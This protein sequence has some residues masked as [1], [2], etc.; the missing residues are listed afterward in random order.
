M[1]ISQAASSGGGG[2]GVADFAIAASSASGSVSAGLPATTTLTLT[3]SN[4][5]NQAVA[6]SCRWVAGRRDLRVLADLCH[7]E[8]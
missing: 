6:L 3:P 8:W 7:G 4:G 5:F 1:L 2:G